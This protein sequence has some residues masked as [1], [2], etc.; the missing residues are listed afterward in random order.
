LQRASTLINPGAAQGTKRGSETLSALKVRGLDGT[1]DAKTFQI[2]LLD[3]GKTGSDLGAN[4]VSINIKKYE[5]IK[6]TLGPQGASITR[7]LAH[8]FGHAAL[9]VADIDYVGG[10][11]MLN[12]D[13]NENVIMQELRPTHHE[14]YDRTQY[15]PLGF[16]RSP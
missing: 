9:G 15:E 4:Y 5:I 3:R 1:S 10:A 7:R 11:R 6:T 2:Y 13:L 16:G 8:E 12:V 14:Y